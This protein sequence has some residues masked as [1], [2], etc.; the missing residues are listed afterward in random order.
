[1]RRSSPDSSFSQDGYIIDTRGNDFFS[2]S[3]KVLELADGAVLIPGFFGDKFI[4]RKYDSSGNIVTTFGT[5]G[6]AKMPA[7]DNHL[8]AVLDIDVTDDNRIW[9]LTEYVNRAV[10]LSDSDQAY[11]TIMSFNGNGSVNTSFNGTGYKIDQPFTN[12]YYHPKAMAIDKRANNTA[13]YVGSWAYLDGHNICSAGYG[14]WCI[15]KYNMNGT[16]ETGFNSTGIMQDNA[17]VIKQAPTAGP[18][19][20]IHDMQIMSNGNLVAAGNMFAPDSSFF[21]IKLLPNGQWDN[22]FGSN[23]RHIHKVSFEVPSNDMSDCQVL[24]DGSAIFYSSYRQGSDTIIVNIAKSGNTGTTINSFGTNGKITAGYSG[25]PVFIFRKDQSFLAAY[26]RKYGATDQKIEFIHYSANGVQDMS[27]GVGGICQA[28]PRNP[29]TYVNR[30]SI[31][32]GI[33]T[34][35]ETGLYLAT[36]NQPQGTTWFGSGLF[37]FKSPGLAPASVQS[38]HVPTLY[39]IYPNPLQASGNLTV[40]CDHEI[41]TLNLYSVQ[42]SLV[43]TN[44]QFINDKKAVLHFPENISPGVYYLFINNEKTSAVVIK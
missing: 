17:S 20:V 22:S 9:V 37:K 41:K 21:S 19:A 40:E 24:P 27:F 25:E 44:A 33:W 12:Y 36:Q 34:K 18:L 39:S 32:H 35:N 5:N 13:I 31:R 6:E 16:R 28:H 43:K 11:I 23:G 10:T 38:I 29:D 3:T 2:P 42:G 30:S 15:S 7:L 26:Y 8:S 1:M 14:Q 4:L